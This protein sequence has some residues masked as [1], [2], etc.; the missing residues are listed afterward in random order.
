MRIPANMGQPIINVDTQEVWAY[1]AEDRTFSN[2]V[3]LFPTRTMLLGGS[4][5][6]DGSQFNRSPSV[7]WHNDVWAAGPSTLQKDFNEHPWFFMH[8]LQGPE[9]KLAAIRLLLKDPAFAQYFQSDIQSL[10]AYE[11]YMTKRARIT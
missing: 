2:T 1:W 10:K 4:D 11:G 9:A 5:F 3:V 6:D 8:P 7:H